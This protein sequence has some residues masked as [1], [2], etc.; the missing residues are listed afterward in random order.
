M[1]KMAFM[2][3]MMLCAQSCSRTDSVFDDI[4]SNTIWVQ[5]YVTGTR[6]DPEIVLGLPDWIEDRLEKEG[7]S[8]KTVTDTVW[9]INY[10]KGKITLI[11]SNDDKCTFEKVSTPIGT[12]QIRTSICSSYHYPDQT[13]SFYENDFILCELTVRNDTLTV[14]KYNIGEGL[15]HECVYEDMQYVGVVSECSI[16]GKSEPYPCLDEETEIFRMTYIRSGYDIKLQGARELTGVL[17]S[18]CNEIDFEEIGTLY[19]QI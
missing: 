5:D 15:Q 10:I 4:L 17:N 11:F 7:L 19:I 2:L 12:Y 18:C 1:R 6:L 16:L 9:D 8:S 3:I 14:K 13:H